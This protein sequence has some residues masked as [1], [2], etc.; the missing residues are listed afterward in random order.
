MPLRNYSLA[1]VRLG[2][3]YCPLLESEGGL[4][5]LEPIAENAHARFPL[6][7]QL[8]QQ[9]MRRCHQFRLCVDSQSVDDLDGVAAGADVDIPDDSDADDVMDADD[10][11]DDSDDDSGL[12]Y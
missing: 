6:V 7:R 12:D 3:K 5:L 4:S 11:Y 2:A 10:E 8:A 1:A 9:V